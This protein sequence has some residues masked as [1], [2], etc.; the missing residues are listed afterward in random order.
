MTDKT[1]DLYKLFNTRINDLRK[2]IDHVYLTYD[3]YELTREQLGD[4]ERWIRQERLYGAL[5]I[6]ELE[7]ILRHE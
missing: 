2:V 3:T 4:V 7:G 5:W 6:I 1:I